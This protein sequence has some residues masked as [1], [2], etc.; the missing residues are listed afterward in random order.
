MHVNNPKARTVVLS[1]LEEEN[2]IDVWR[3][4]HEDTKTYTWRR[5]NPTKKQARLDYVLVSDPLFSFVVDSDI[6]P[7]Y[8]TDH[9]GF[10]IKFKLQENERRIGY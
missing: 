6:V 10:I 8:R 9:S 2:F 4:L 3:V 5:L 1:L 7:G